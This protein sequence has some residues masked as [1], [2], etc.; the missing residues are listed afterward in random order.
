MDQS[1]ITV[2]RL[3]VGMQVQMRFPGREI[4]VKNFFTADVLSQLRVEDLTKFTI[5]VNGEAADDDTL[6]TNLDEVTLTGKVA[7]G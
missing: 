7:G 1:L 3:P 5:E 2:I 6:I 4:A